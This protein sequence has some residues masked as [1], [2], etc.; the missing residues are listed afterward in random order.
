MFEFTIDF[1]GLVPDG[2]YD[3]EEDD[4]KTFMA[5]ADGNASIP[6]DLKDGQEAVIKR[7]PKSASYM[8]TE[9]ASDHVAGFRL[10]PEDMDEE[11]AKIIVREASNEGEARKILSTAEETVDSMD[12]TIIV[13]WENNKDQATLTGLAGPDYPVYMAVLAVLVLASG[14]IIRKRNS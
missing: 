12:G 14:L 4:E 9:A 8:I 13:L 3:I 7:L 6:V 1:T 10:F 2:A 5:D 11:D